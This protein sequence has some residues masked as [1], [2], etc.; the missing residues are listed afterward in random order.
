[1]ESRYKAEE[2]SKERV[3]GMN[4]MKLIPLTQGKSAIVDKDMFNCLN[5]YKWCAQKVGNCYYA[6][7]NVGTKPNRTIQYMHNMILSIPKNSN[8]ET[9]HRNGNGLD[10]RRCNLRL[11][12]SSQNMQNSRKRLKCS[13][14]YKGVSWNKQRK[15]WRTYIGHPQTHLGYFDDEIE[16]ARVYDKTAMKLFGEFANLNFP[17]E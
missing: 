7:R 8:L 2:V 13:S 16:A 15:M 6:F 4:K 3:L 14:K 11:S 5:Q 9:D 10:N 17:K 12:T 1:M